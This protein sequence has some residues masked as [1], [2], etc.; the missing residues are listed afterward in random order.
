M[1]PRHDI[2]TGG[3]EQDIIYGYFHVVEFTQSNTNHMYRNNKRQFHFSTCNRFMVRRLF[4]GLS[5]QR[6]RFDFSPYN[7]G[8][9]VENVVFLQVLFLASLNF[10]VFVSDK[11]ATQFNY[12]QRYV[13]SK[14]QRTL[15]IIRIKSE[16]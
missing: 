11:S 8:L 13:N 16:E 4:T 5:P 10:H 6:D 12:Y 15:K 9:V 1:I 7:V 2:K 3:N 14:T